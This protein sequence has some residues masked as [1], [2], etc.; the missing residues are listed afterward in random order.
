MAIMPLQPLDLMG[1]DIVGRFPDTPRGNK[2]IVIAVDYFT[3]FLF[4]RAVPDSQG[5]SAVALLITVVRMFGWMRAVYTNN[6]THFVQGE[7]GKQLQRFHVVHLPAP[8]SHP[9]SVGLAE[10][11]VR[12]LVA[13]LKVTVMANKAAS[14][15]W[16]LYI[17]SVVHC[18]NTHLLKVHSFSPAEL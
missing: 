8:K 2:Y 1:F 15:D 13:C 10:R 14:T 18:I 9:Q 7:F 4:A 5:R 12:L 17:D 11:Y 6:G 16:D 3:R